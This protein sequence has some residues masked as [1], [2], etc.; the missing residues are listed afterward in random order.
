[1]R[2][3]SCTDLQPAAVYFRDNAQSLENHICLSKVSH[4]HHIDHSEFYNLIAEVE[5][6][7]PLQNHEL[8]WAWRPIIYS[9]KMIQ[10]FYG[11]LKRDIWTFKVITM[12][13]AVIV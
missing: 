7:R 2:S 12:V 1:M 5:N 6:K 4:N 8:H 3:E 10:R 9:G 13:L 11:I